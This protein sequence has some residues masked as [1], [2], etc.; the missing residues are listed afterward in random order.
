[1]PRDT[2]ATIFAEEEIS[3]G[4]TGFIHN[5]SFSEPRGGTCGGRRVGLSQARV[6]RDEAL[7]WTVVCVEFWYHYQ[8]VA[9]VLL[10]AHAQL[11]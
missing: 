1:M 7:L 3:L 2:Q 11:E 10:L 5:F 8:L 9:R 6:M 4:C